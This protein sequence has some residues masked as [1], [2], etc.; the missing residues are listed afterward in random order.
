MHID[1]SVP[2]G[3]KATTVKSTATTV[4]QMLVEMEQ[5]VL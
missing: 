3:L 4:S 5:H 1:V 2:L